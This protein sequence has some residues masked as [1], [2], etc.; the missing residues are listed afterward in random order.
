LL[1]TADLVDGL[2]RVRSSRPAKKLRIEAAKIVTS[3]LG[4]QSKSLESSWKEK[5]EIWILI[6]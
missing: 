5:M 4:A 2:R 6:Y 1:E 3:R